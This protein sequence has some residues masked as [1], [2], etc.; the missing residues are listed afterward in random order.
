MTA[1]LMLALSGALLRFQSVP[2]NESRKADLPTAMSLGQDEEP[3]RN[4]NQMR[5]GIRECFLLGSTSFG[6]GF[7][8]NTT[9]VGWSDFF[10]TGIGFSLNSDHLIRTSSQVAVGPYFGTTVDFF[11]GES[12]NVGSPIFTTLEPETLIMIRVVVGV[13]ARENLGS[14]F[15]LEEYFGLGAA[16]YPAT[17]TKQVFFSQEQLLFETSVGFT[18]ELGL[19]AGFSVSKVT[20]LGIGLAFENSSRPQMGDQ[21]SSGHFNSASNLSLSFLVN[22][23]F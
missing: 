8:S 18:V 3:L 2:E 7:G 19:R 23:N 14:G 17:Q 13:R 11:Q 15:F 4:Y 21:F 9:K 12:T 22:F 20:E 16:F 1:M 6:A 5:I 10:S